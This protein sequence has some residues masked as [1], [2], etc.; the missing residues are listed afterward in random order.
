MSDR[1]HPDATPWRPAPT[2]EP[3]HAEAAS[4]AAA[5]LAAILDAMPPD[6]PLNEALGATLLTYAAMAHEAGLT[7]DD[8]TEALKAQW[9]AGD[10]LRKAIKGGGPR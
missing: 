6:T 2:P 9:E 4:G 10:Q 8:A 7:L 5:V 3:E 1:D